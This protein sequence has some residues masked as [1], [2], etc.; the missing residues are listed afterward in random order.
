MTHNREPDRMLISPGRE[1]FRCPLLSVQSHDCATP[2]RSSH[3][4]IFTIVTRSWVN[5]VP[6]TPAGEILLVRQH[7]FGTD[8]VTLETPGGVMD[9]GE[10]PLEAARREL[11]EETGYRA[12]AFAPLPWFHPNPAIQDNRIHYFIAWDV[13]PAQV[14]ERHPDPFES[15]VIELTPW[16]A[17][18]AAV[19]SGGISHSL[20]ALPLL[21]AEPHL[22]QRQF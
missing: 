13:E 19:H 16:R 3:M 14:R 2:D 15:L 21:L 7:R 8:T 5:V 12:K 20:A 11:E 18:I 22:R 10:D 17:A 6:V 4:T 1:E 9:A